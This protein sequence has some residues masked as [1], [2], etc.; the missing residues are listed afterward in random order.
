M[1]K[2]KEAYDICFVACSNDHIHIELRDENE[3]SFAEIVLY[4]EQEILQ[5]IDVLK[6]GLIQINADKVLQ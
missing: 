1:A 4:D 3:V 2:I 6:E 5:M